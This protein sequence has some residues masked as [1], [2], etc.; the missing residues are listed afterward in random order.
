M[1]TLL[2]IFLFVITFLAG[3]DVVPELTFKPVVPVATADNPIVVDEEDVIVKPKPS[4]YNF[5][6]VMGLCSQNTPEE[7]L[8][9]RECLQITKECLGKAKDVEINTIVECSNLYWESQ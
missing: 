6:I 9:N 3:C 1:K 4:T 7:P 8:V 2:A 5:S